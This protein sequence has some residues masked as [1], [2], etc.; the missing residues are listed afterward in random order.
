ME[1]VRAGLLVRSLFSILAHACSTLDR[2][3][4]VFV[5]RMS[6]SLFFLLVV[7]EAQLCKLAYT[8]FS[9]EVLTWMVDFYEMKL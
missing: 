3:T 2:L 5:V 7:V 6:E 9:V 1:G 8:N 4:L